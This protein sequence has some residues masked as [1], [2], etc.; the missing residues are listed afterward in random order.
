MFLSVF[1]FMFG[2]L[3]LFVFITLCLVD[4]EKVGGRLPSLVELLE[5]EDDEE[6]E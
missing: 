1:L 4:F 6:H 2:V 3:F 5:P